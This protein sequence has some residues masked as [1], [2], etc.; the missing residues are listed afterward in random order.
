MKSK[1]FAGTKPAVIDIKLARVGDLFATLDPSP[2]VER[3]IDDA[4]EEFLVDSAHEKPRDAPLII[5]IH[6]PAADPAA[7]ADALAAAIRNYFAFMRDREAGRIRRLFEEGRQSLAIGVV[8]LVICVSLGQAAFTLYG[9]A[10]GMLARE[11]LSIIG[12]VA[13]WRP[14]E[15]F[16]Y[17]WRPLRRRR[18]VFEQLAE[19]RVELRIDNPS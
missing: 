18:R 5:A 7:D 12:W 6:L 11:G 16:L 10:A 15:I 2:L 13:N 17:D 1:Q 19:A 4:V 8:F 14:V 3:D 9:G